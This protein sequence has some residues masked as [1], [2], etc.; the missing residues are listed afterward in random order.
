MVFQQ[1]QVGAWHGLGVT[2]WG[3]LLRDPRPQ[4]GP[5]WSTPLLMDLEP[6]QG[7]CTQSKARTGS[8]MAELTVTC[9][10]GSQASHGSAW[11]HN[12]CPLLRVPTQEKAVTA[13]L[14]G[15][16]H[17][18]PTQSPPIL[19]VNLELVMLKLLEVWLAHDL[20]GMCLL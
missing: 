3:L 15:T 4:Q 7:V 17:Q 12:V 16:P 2:E 18:L 19:A 10:L 5:S 1:H 11:L 14:A 9:H 20:W 6:C 13:E 8:G